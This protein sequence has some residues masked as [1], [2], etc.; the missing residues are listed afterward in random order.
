[1]SFLGKLRLIE[2]LDQIYKAGAEIKAAHINAGRLLSTRL[3]KQIHD[4]IKEMGTID[5]FNIWEPICFQM[6]GIGA[7]RIMKIIDLGQQIP[8]EIGNTNRLIAEG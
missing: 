5:T 7:I 3:K 1:M 6:E 8:I 2:K 4:A